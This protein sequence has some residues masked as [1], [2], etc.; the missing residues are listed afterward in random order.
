MSSDSLGLSSTTSTRPSKPTN[1]WLGLAPYS[2]QDCAMFFGRERETAEVLRFIERDALTVVFGRSGLGKTSLLRAGVIPQLRELAFFPIGLRLDFSGQGLSPARQVM[3][4]AREAALVNRFVLENNPGDAPDLTLWEFFHTAE[5]WSPRNDQLTP[6]LVID[7]FEEVF[8]IGHNIREVAE[9]LEQLADLVENRIPRTVQERVEQSGQPLS[10]DAGVRNYKIVVSLREDFVSKLDS[11]RAGMPAIMRNRFALNPLASERALAVI[12]QAGAEWV[13]EDVARDMVAAVAGNIDETESALEFSAGAEIEPAYLSVMCH[14]LFQRMLALDRSSITHD[15]VRQE[16]GGILES[17]YERSFEGLDDKVRAFV[18]DRLLTASGFRAAIPVAEA[19]SEG[20]TAHALDVLVDRRLLRFEDR[21][22]T[23]HAELSHDLLTRVVLRSRDQRHSRLALEEETLRQAELRRAFHARI[24]STIIAASAAVIFFGGL[25]VWALFETHKANDA[26]VMAVWEGQDAEKA[27][28]EAQNSLLKLNQQDIKLKNQ[29]D[30]L[31]IEVRQ[32][33]KERQNAEKSKHQE[34]L[35]QERA[36]EAEY[37]KLEN[38]QNVSESSYQD[39][40]KLLE[41]RG[42]TSTN[43]SEDL[44]DPELKTKMDNIKRALKDDQEFQVEH[45]D[46]KQVISSEMGNLFG[47][48]DLKSRAQVF[49][50]KDFNAFL[51]FTRQ[52]LAT[53]DDPWL[54][55]RALRKLAQAANIEFRRPDAVAAKALL[56]EF[57]RDQEKFQRRTDRETFSAEAWDALDDAYEVCVKAE[58]SSDTADA[59][60]WFH[61]AVDAEQAAARKDKKYLHDAVTVWERLGNFDY[62]LKNYQEATH[63]FSGA[64]DTARAMARTSDN[65]WEDSDLSEALLLRAESERKDSKFAPSRKD[66]EDSLKMT[67]KLQK[68]QTNLSRM[69][70]VYEGLGILDTLAGDYKSALGQFEH[71]KH[72]DLSLSNNDIKRRE[73]LV[74]DFRHIV[75]TQHQLKNQA[76]ERAQLQES[77]TTFKQWSDP[78]DQESTERHINAMVALAEFDLDK[79]QSK[80]AREEY[81][82]AADE[83]NKYAQANSRLSYQELKYKAL[84]ASGLSAYKE[85]DYAR[86]LEYFGDSRK[87][88]EEMPDDKYREDARPRSRLLTALIYQVQDR[89]SEAE[90]QYREAL[91]MVRQLIVKDCPDNIRLFSKVETGHIGSLVDLKRIDDART[92]LGEVTQSVDKNCSSIEKDSEVRVTVAQLWIDL[93]DKFSGTTGTLS[94]TDDA[95]NSYRKASPIVYG[96]MA[97]NC[98]TSL[99]QFASVEAGIMKSLVSM[100]KEDEAR[101]EGMRA[102]E[103]LDAKCKA[104]DKNSNSDAKTAM[105]EIWGNLSYDFVRF[106]DGKDALMCAEKGLDFDP[107]Q[108][109]IKVNRA[110]GLLFSGRLFEAKQSYGEIKIL[111]WRDHLLAEDICSDFKEFESMGLSNPT[112]YGVRRTL[113]GC[114]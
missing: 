39:A 23:S 24:R 109:W 12:V 1:P 74:T 70:Y 30:Q 7:Q 72:I 20:M 21:L 44:T 60:V 27:K 108:L 96:L 69:A 86:A 106:G 65:D 94:L 14:E 34:A 11:L 26:L 32:E 97:E 55:A 111:K 75:D 36:D 45:P 10:I 80:E 107:S 46:N 16:H 103:F 9:F 31:E 4:L 41:N 110:H 47:I 28:T 112:M 56:E 25:A 62:S 43:G 68:N 82:A 93:G 76:G 42:K 40:L 18:E 98:L 113:N 64:A 81:Q 51:D 50:A 52:V 48:A 71:E 99:D 73:M 13:A 89:Q 88:T 61:L 38:E 105:A 15:L 2:E 66:Y 77:E 85:K 37:R 58:P 101:S 8:T 100:K 29:H 3:E 92:E 78:T 19:I 95:M 22:G 90:K 53:N 57:K 102:I 87:T 33:K 79:D 17:L 83:A 91:P 84:V 54:Q 59:R 67:E 114:K 6:V 5:F 104:V 63:D 35:T 49:N